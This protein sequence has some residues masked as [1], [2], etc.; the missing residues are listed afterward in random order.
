MSEDLTKYLPGHFDSCMTPVGFEGFEGQGLRAR[1]CCRRYL[2]PYFG[3]I[4]LPHVDW[5]AQCL[6]QRKSKR[7]I[8][9]E[10]MEI[11]KRR[12]HFFYTFLYLLGEGTNRRNVPRRRRGAQ[13]TR[14]Q[15]GVVGSTNTAR[16]KKVISSPFS[17][18]NP[19]FFLCMRHLLFR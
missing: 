14:Q 6:A 3:Y 2:T 16:K 17:R 4:I 9:K 18:G 1:L 19:F 12:K 11:D 5:P 15:N 8:Q 13:N 10:K 7:N